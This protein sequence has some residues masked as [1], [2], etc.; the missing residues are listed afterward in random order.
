[1]PRA[2]D[3][4]RATTTTTVLAVAA[5]CAAVT[6]AR[7]DELDQGRARAQVC[8]VCHGALGV[9]AQPDAPNLAGQPSV[10]L[11][12][13]LRAFRNGS[14]KH[15]VMNVLARTLTDDDIALLAAWFSAIRVEATAPR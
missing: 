3:R 15:E 13:Q 9:S 5:L 12:S 1:M 6:P 4:G 10:Y 11:S 7:S 8:A 2:I 14:R